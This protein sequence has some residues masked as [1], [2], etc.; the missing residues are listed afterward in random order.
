MAN[1]QA[2][3]HAAGWCGSSGAA[4]AAALTATAPVIARATSERVRNE[5]GEVCASAAAA[6]RTN[7][8]GS[9]RRLQQLWVVE[10]KQRQVDVP[11][12]PPWM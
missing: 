9:G 5:R 6:D 1:G 10:G 8:P 7:G 3:D 11:H 2:G 4:A 12:W